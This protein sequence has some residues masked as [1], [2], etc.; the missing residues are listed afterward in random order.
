MATKGKS[1]RQNWSEHEMQVQVSLWSEEG[2]KREL[3]KVGTK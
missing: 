2:L 3:E 1:H